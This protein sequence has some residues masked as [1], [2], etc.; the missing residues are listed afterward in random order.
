MA[1]QPKTDASA[2]AD[3]AQRHSGGEGY[4]PRMKTIYREQIRSTISPA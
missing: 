1:K 3:Q 2:V 4:E